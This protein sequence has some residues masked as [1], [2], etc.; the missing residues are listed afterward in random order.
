MYLDGRGVNQSDSR[1][2]HYF[3]L[4]CDGGDPPSCRAL[5]SLYYLGPGVR[6]STATSLRYARMACR[7]G[8]TIGCE[9]AGVRPE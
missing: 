2:A 9:L 3:T 8:D 1:A 7:M 6:Q 5:S 4:A